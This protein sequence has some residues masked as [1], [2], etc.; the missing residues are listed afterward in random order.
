MEA[1]SIGMSIPLTGIHNLETLGT[2]QGLATAGCNW[3]LSRYF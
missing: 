3:G 1:S 2:G